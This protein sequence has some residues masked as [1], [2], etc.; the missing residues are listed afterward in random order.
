MTRMD[1]SKTNTVPAAFIEETKA[2]IR[3][4]HRRIQHC[5]RQLSND[6]IWRRPTPHVNSIGTILRHLCGNMCQWFLH[7]VGGDKDIRNRA[8]EFADGDETPKDELTRDLD[9]LLDDTYSTI[10]ELDPD[11]LLEA[12]RIQG[13]DTNVLSALYSTVTHFEGHAQQIVYVTHMHLGEDY[14]PFWKPEE[15]E[16]AE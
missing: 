15:A 4:E 6:Q 8:A 14:A 3:Q 12:R 7:G 16:Q 9:R 10:D 13:F 5:L 2:A 11:A 1:T